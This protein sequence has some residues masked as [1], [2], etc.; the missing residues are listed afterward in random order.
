MDFL[1]ALYN[2]YNDS[3][4]N[5]KVDKHDDDNTILLP[6]YHTSMKSRG[7]DIIQVTLT[8]NSQILD[9]EYLSADEVIVFPVTNDSVARSGKNPPSHPLVDKIS[10][11]LP[12]NK[13]M[14]DLYRTE[15]NNWYHAVGNSEVKSY[16]EIIK[17]F[18]YQENF[19]DDLLNSMYKNKMIEYT[20]KGLEVQ[21]V[22]KEGDK[23]KKI[24]LSKIF[25]TFA[26][27][28]FTGYKTVSVTE[29][30][31]LHNDYI[32]Y[33]ESQATNTVLCNIGKEEQQLTTKH[34][35]LM[36]NAKLISVSNHIETYKGRFQTGSD[37]IQ[38]GYRTSEK[39][40]LM[41]KYLLENKNSR[42][43]LGGQQYLINWFSKDIANTEEV[44]ITLPI[45]FDFGDNQ[46]EW[47]IPSV[48]QANKKV[49]DSFISGRKLYD[50]DSD[51]YVAIIDKASN[52]RISLKYFKELKVSQLQTNL[53]KWHNKYSWNVY[54]KNLG[55]TSPITPS[56][57]QIVLAA[58]G[59]E[60]NG[61]L[62][63]DNDNFKKDQFQNLVI[64]LLDGQS[65]PANILTA[66]AMNI[67]KRLNYPKTWNQIQF[68][69]LA[70]FSHYREEIPF[71]LDRQYQNRSYLFGRLLAVLDQL[72][73]LTYMTTP[74]K[75]NKQKENK[76]VTN[77][78]KFWTSY[79]S[80][81]AS[82]MATLI[83]KTKVY[84]KSLVNSKPG[85]F[86]KL[87]NE[88]IEI[89]N[90]LSVYLTKE[91]EANKPLDYRF[92]FGYYAEIQFIFTKSEKNESEE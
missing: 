15:F 68:T 40:H 5:D 45:F 28:D 42:R 21:Y 66:L 53:E 17:N 18:I 31:A 27:A 61:K 25:L 87:E 14:N 20:R 3:L 64:R 22:E 69:T 84:E 1:T 79:T 91:N 54:Y 13:E 7:N 81:P 47:A 56:I 29:Y 32:K 77:A 90:A 59:V 4:K 80:H 38:I 82:T 24:D 37:I 11:M 26:I 49:G 51:Y 33:V 39:I 83:Q 75:E 43:W 8:K 63:L 88:K 12:E 30:V 46:S 76:R 86:Y 44:D 74:E 92:I 23:V 57:S 35:G 50:K 70:L 2:S 78:Q 16:L 48:S 55:K 58:Y 10:Y 89:I 60:R 9:V 73:A 65:V 71:M 72:E 36:G 67:R 34:R 62:E 19:V 41:L 85:M 6:I 52:G